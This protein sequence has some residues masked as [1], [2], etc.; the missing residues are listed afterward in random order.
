M[1]WQT[2]RHHVGE[3]EALWQVVRER[4][5]E[6]IVAKRLGSP[7]RPGRRSRDWIKVR[8]R[9]GQELVIGGWMPGEGT[10]GGRVGSLLVGHWDATPEEAAWLGRPQRL[11]YAGGVGTGFTQAMLDRLTAMLAP[12]RREH[13]PFELGEDPRAKY[14]QRARARGAGPIWVDRS[15]SARSSSAS[16]RTRGPC[17]SPRSRGCATTR[18]PA[19]SSAR[20]LPGGDR[21]SRLR[22]RHAMTDGRTYA[23][24]NP[25]QKVLRR[26]A[27]SGPGSWLFAR[28]LHHI[29][30]P[31][32]G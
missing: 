10:R 8:N 25:V 5:L 7:Y 20:R 24:A 4:N 12:L 17:A 19:R 15:W 13:S 26:F 30:G 1:H 14:A 18:T 28:V 27:A 16:G 2:P 3:G 31:C 29:D 6:G 21:S 32:I 9:S 11:V 23:E 22:G